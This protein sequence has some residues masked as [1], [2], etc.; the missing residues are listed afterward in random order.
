MTT[1][2]VLRSLR[3]LLQ[4]NDAKMAAIFA[5]AGVEVTPAQARAMTGREEDE[6]AEECTEQ[7]LSLF[8]DGLVIHMRGPREDAPVRAPVELTNNEILKKLRI[9][10]SL[11]ND[12]VIEVL[13]LGGQSMSKSELTALFRKPEHRHF[14]PCGNQVLRKFLKGLA[15]RLRPELADRPPKPYLG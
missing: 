13:A 15:L 3:F 8:L 7:M 12:D 4:L 1:N 9:A 5:L 2:D 14:R 10:M 11:R 6:D